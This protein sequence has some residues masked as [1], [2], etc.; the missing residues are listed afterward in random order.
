MNGLGTI[1]MVIGVLAMWASHVIFAAEV[2]RA[3]RILDARLKV[4]ENKWQDKKKK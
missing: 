1:L 3:I 2:Q 4:L